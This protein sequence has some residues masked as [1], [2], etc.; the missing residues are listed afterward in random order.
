MI[1]HI[2]RQY[3]SVNFVGNATR[4]VHKITREYHGNPWYPRRIVYATA[5]LSFCKYWPDDVLFKPKLV[6]NI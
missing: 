4:L 2:T 1:V 3:I 6:T 5:F